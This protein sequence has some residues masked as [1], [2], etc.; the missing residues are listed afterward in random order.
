MPFV[1]AG[2][3]RLEY[4][5][6]GEGDDILVL[7]HG[8]GSSAI[9]WHQVQQL[10][11]ASGF[12]TVAIS[13]PG[14]GGSD[15]TQDLGDYNPAAYA[16]DIRAALDALGISR[17]AIAGH[18]LGVSNVLNLAEG[19]GNGL[20]IRGL[21]LMAGGHVIGRDA[22]SPDKAEVI[23][24]KHR[25]PD[26]STESERRDAWEVVHQGL[27]I[28]IRDQ[29]WRDIQNNPRERN[30]GQRLGARKD[31][32]PFAAG[33]DIPVLIISGDA[34]SV[35][36]LSYTLA[37]YPEFKA[38]VRHCHVMYGVDHYPNAEVPEEVASVYTRFL[39][40]HQLPG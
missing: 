10:M 33:C 36:P 2:E 28:E 4:F 1:Q 5:E 40:D 3:K 18:S 22:E 26:P 14:A 20:S 32:R 39:R 19:Y 38:E 17:F 31:M 29:L 16:R 25:D 37:M 6:S 13:L 15:R 12:R 30:L 11:A 27:P 35:V 7:I 34:D 23:K 24:A 9:I 21:I 8:A